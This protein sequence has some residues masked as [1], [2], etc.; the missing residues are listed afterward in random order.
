MPQGFSHTAAE[1]AEPGLTVIIVSYNSGRLILEGLP[2]VVRSPRWRTLIIDNNSPDGSAALLRE[3]FGEERVL[4]LPRNE[5]YGRG[6]NAALTRLQTRYALLMNPDIVADEGQVA[7]FFASAT[8]PPGPA[9]IVAPATNPRDHRHRG[10]L[11][12]DN[13]LGAAMLFDREH[14]AGIG[15]FDEQLFLYYE[16]KD[17]CR[18]VLAAGG[19]IYLDS[20][21]HFLHHKGTSS[22]ESREVI[23]LKHWHVGWSSCYYLRKHGL[24][25]GRRRPRAL[26][27]KYR[28]KA[29]LYRKPAERLK[30]RAR[31]AGVAAY[32]RGLAAFSDS[33]EPRARPAPTAG[34]PAP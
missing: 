32:L 4:A 5:G 11:P 30:Y 16:E 19:A 7:A 22:G 12:R 1:G 26:L 18:R 25:K 3:H 15:W 17:L 24:D 20:D 33:G 29:L 13:V 23:Y 6:A 8:R 34:A 10:L 14:M 21:H 27:L 28:L 31:S 2:S 9:A